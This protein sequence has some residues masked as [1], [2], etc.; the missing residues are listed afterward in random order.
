MNSNHTADQ[1]PRPNPPASAARQVDW[2]ILDAGAARVALA[3]MAPD[4]PVLLINLDET[5]FGSSMNQAGWEAMFA[6]SLL[7]QL[8]PAVPDVLTGPGGLELQPAARLAFC[9]GIELSL[10]STEFSLLQDLLSRSGAVAS[11]DDL[12]RAIWGHDTLGA[13][14]YVEAHISRLRRKLRDAGAP[15]VIETVRGAGYRVR[16]VRAELS[17]MPSMRPDR[18]TPMRPTPTSEYET[19]DAA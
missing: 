10:T 6:Q 1:P 4:A 9:D 11:V 3:S 5:G 17:S 19:R 2:Q 13:P 7:S 12:S 15:R 14:N 8:A 18:M 16:Q